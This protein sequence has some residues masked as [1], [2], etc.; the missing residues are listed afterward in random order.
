MVD[1]RRIIKA[2]TIS[3]TLVERLIVRVF[4]VCQ[5]WLVFGI[6]A[7]SLLSRSTYGAAVVDDAELPWCHAMYA[8]VAMDGV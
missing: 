5:R 3:I 6:I 8:L 7:L 2:L 1:G 4:A